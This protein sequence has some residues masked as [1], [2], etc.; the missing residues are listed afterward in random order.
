MHSTCAACGRLPI[1]VPEAARALVVVGPRTPWRAS[2]LWA[3][4]PT[5]WALRACASYVC[6]VFLGSVTARLCARRRT[7]FRAAFPSHQAA[8]LPMRQ[9]ACVMVCMPN[10]RAPRC[11]V[12]TP[13]EPHVTTTQ[14]NQEGTT[15]FCVARPTPSAQRLLDV[16]RSC[17]A[18]RLPESS[19]RA[20]IARAQS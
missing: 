12:P 19:T 3:S 9:A 13:S 15:S 20:S 10:P 6:V 11:Q 2:E 16:D 14:R 1:V 4:E 18:R 7:R 17:V 5:R 8:N